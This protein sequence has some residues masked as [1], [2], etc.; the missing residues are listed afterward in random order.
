MSN[1]RRCHDRGAQYFFTLVTYKRRRI[2][3]SNAAVELLRSAIR[4]VMNNHPF[5]IDAMVVLPDHLHCIWQLP[6]NDAD[7]STRWMLIKKYVS[8]SVD[9][10]KNHRGEKK[11]WQRRFWE[12]LIRDD[13]DLQR[14][15]DY[16]HYNPVKHSYV[17][18][19]AQWCYSSFSHSVE[20]GICD[21]NWGACEPATI[22]SMNYE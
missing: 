12:H 11:I 3:E 7:Y 16:I 21:A 15:F 4:S 1:Y 13:D 10:P 2:F 8:A 19:P 22:A 9:S 18:S 6:N 14:H 5:K 17:M 20:N